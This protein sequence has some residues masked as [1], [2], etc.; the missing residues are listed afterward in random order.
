MNLSKMVVIG[1]VMSTAVLL[2]GC[3]YQP[4]FFS[5]HALESAVRD[6]L[7][8]PFGILTA[9]DLLGVREL[10]GRGLGIEDLRG[11]ELCSNLAWLDLDTNKISDLS[12]LEQL[13]RPDSPFNSPLVYLNLDGNE[14]T[15]ITPLAGLLNLQGVSLFGN[16]VADIGPLVVNATNMGLGEG[17]YVILDASTL[18]EEAIAVDIP[19]LLSFGVNVIGAV[20][21]DAPAAKTEE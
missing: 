5:D 6:E 12:P 16:Q 9:A 19:M 4:V 20:E 3:P 17:D 2:V 1:F 13:G 11:L 15:D 10:D 18:N 21:I 8:K 7:K 14:I